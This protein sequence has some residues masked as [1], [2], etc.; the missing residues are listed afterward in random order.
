MAG[1]LFLF[2]PSSH[3]FPRTVIVHLPF[4]SLLLSPFPI[5]LFP[6]L[7]HLFHPPHPTHIHPLHP[8]IHPIYFSSLTDPTCQQLADS[9][10]YSSTR[11]PNFVVSSSSSVTVPA[12]KT[13][14]SFT[15]FFF[16]FFFFLNHSFLHLPP[17]Y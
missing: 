17:S 5:L 4:P 16:F 12:V 6:S 1:C 13:L 15:F 11:W 7:P 9:L 2:L 8:S 14:F 3:D 10:C